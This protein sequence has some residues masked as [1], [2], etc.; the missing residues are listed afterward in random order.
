VP[1]FGVH[2]LRHRLYRCAAELERAAAEGDADRGA[3]AKPSA[4]GEAKN[5]E[6]EDFPFANTIGIMTGF[7]CGPLPH[8]RRRSVTLFCRRSQ[9]RRK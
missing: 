7:T 2:P 8:L 6:D 9:A 5:L 1:I 3:I 4:E